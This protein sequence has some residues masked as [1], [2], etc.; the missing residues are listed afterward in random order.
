MPAT[1]EDLFRRLEALGIETITHEHPPLFTVEESKAL[2]GSMPGG[3]HK[4][5]FLR[6]KKKQ[7][8]LVVMPEDKDIDLKTLP[9]RIGSARLSFGSADRLMEFL[10]VTPGSVT[11]FALI[12]DTDQAVNVVLDA[13]MLEV[14]PLNYHPLVNTMT[15]A[16][17]PDD[18]LTFIADCGH[19]P[20]IV[21]L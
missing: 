17:A 16:I 12:N 5:L 6:D 20:S 13:Q 2:R 3:H 15:T 8:W 4:N 11:P 10:G 7:T 21:A 9:D 1:P 19:K 14:S 18:L